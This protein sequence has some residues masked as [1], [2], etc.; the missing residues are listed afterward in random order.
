[1][2][3]LGMLIF[4]SALGLC[5]TPYPG[6]WRSLLHNILQHLPPLSP[7]QENQ[8]QFNL[9]K[10]TTISQPSFVVTA[11]AGFLG[12]VV[13][14]WLM[15]N[16]VQDLAVAGLAAFAGGR[17][18]ND[19]VTII[20][21]RMN[22]EPVGGEGSETPICFIATACMG[23]Y[24]HPFVILLSDFRDEWLAKRKWGR[25]FIKQYYNY[26]PPVAKIISGSKLLRKVGT[27]LIVKPLV[28]IARL[29]LK[30]R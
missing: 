7:E 15:Y 20:M 8:L 24:N 21:S 6:Y 26:S 27:K 9:A 29:L 23:D 17:V 14:G 25:T 22:Q 1:M 4:F 19:G 16:S 12:G 5:G 11:I 30:T 3:I 18:I 13:G 28:V 2:S 10:N